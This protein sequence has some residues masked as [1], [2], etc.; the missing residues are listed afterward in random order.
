MD[1]YIRTDMFKIY[2]KTYVKRSCLVNNK[3]GSKFLVKPFEIL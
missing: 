1:N 3:T 2:Q